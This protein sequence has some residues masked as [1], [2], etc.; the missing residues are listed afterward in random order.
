[1]VAKIEHCKRLQ[2]SV[3]PAARGWARRASAECWHPV[4]CQKIRCETDT[5]L[6]H[7]HPSAMQ[8]PRSD[9]AHSER[10]KTKLCENWASQGRC[11]FGSRCWFAHGQAEIRPM[12]GGVAAAGPAR[13]P[14][15]HAHGPA[16][17][18]P[19][20]T[21]LST[22][23]RV[24]AFMGMAG[25]PLAAGAG[26]DTASPVA[27][28]MLMHSGERRL[29]TA[30][31]QVVC[32]CG[33]QCDALD[34]DTYKRLKDVLDAEGAAAAAAAAAAAMR[35][36]ILSLAPAGVTSNPY[37]SCPPPPQLHG[38]STPALSAATA[39]AA[40]ASA[41]MAPQPYTPPWNWMQEAS[42]RTGSKADTNTPYSSLFHNVT[43]DVQ[44]SKEW[45]CSPEP[46][47]DV[48]DHRLLP[49]SLLDC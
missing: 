43:E 42:V 1:M 21:S 49:T 36:P 26:S 8:S 31:V 20:L 24:D 41:S 6:A 29:Q 3:G 38:Y 32:C 5:Q 7:P 23:L 27:M 45:S 14:H 34:W 16:R 40:V 17:S 33:S 22:K 9:H 15:T 12:R 19:L 11:A 4:L 39:A 47:H 2:R 48:Y 30:F 35:T 18:S 13:T 25:S 46:E 10:Y 44:E 37:A 28:D